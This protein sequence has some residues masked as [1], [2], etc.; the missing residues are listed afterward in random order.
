MVYTIPSEEKS[1]EMIYNADGDSTVLLVSTNAS[2][3]RKF[4]IENGTQIGEFL[5]ESP[6]LQMA[7][8]SVFTG[9]VVIGIAQNQNIIR[10]DSNG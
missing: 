10:F 5:I 9:D 7:K 1:L 6:I 8:I 3:I 2:M 4:E